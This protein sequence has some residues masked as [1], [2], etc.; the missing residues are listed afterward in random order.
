MWKRRCIGAVWKLD[1]PGYG[2]LERYTRRIR[3]IRFFWWN[4][5]LL[6]SIN[7]NVLSKS[8]GFASHFL[9]RNIHIHPWG[10]RYRNWSWLRIQM[11]VL[12]QKFLWKSLKNVSSS[13]K[14]VF[15]KVFEFLC[16]SLVLNRNKD[17]VILRLKIDKR[18]KPP[19]RISAPV[20]P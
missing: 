18:N 20:S 2:L 3:S 8:H 17:S 1:A 15:Y 12:L 13:Q 5:K 11:L 4:V 9:D 19:L 14:V 6:N 16:C 7:S 10:Q